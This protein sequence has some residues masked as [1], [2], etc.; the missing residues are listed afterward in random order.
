MTHISKRLSFRARL[1]YTAV[2]LA[3]L[4]FPMLHL[5]LQLWYINFSS[6]QYS[7]L[8]V[9]CKRA[10]TYSYRAVTSLL[11]A[12]SCLCF[13]RALIFSCGALT[14]LLSNAPCS[15]FARES[16][17]TAM[18]LSRL[19]FPMLHFVYVFTES[20]DLQLHS[21][22]FSSF[23]CQ[24]LFVFCQ[25]ALTCRYG[26]LTSLLLNVKPCLFLIPHS[27]R[28]LLSFVS[29]CTN[30]VTERLGTKLSSIF[31]LH[32]TQTQKYVRCVL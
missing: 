20:L 14:S 22:H 29:L 12:P 18:E 21:S 1:W 16:W 31:C 4:Y 23:Q 10:L 3:V 9:F 15:C 25:R 32:I 26:A 5:D 11:S 17:H 7:T 2:D 19:C 8:F 13:Y 6:F 24:T 27:R 30:T 28:A